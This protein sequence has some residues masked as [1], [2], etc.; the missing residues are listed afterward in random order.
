MNYNEIAEKIIHEV[1]GAKNIDNVYNCM[2][3]LRF[4]LKNES[5]AN[6]EKINQDLWQQKFDRDQMLDFIIFNLI[7]MLKQG[8][9][10]CSFFVKV[11]R[12]LLY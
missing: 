3:R 4:E 11:L 9:T 7:N 8:R 12:E 2:T 10:D 6:D 1:G 5:L